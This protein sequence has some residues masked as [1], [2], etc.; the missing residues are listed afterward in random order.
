MSFSLQLTAFEE[1]KRRDQR[2]YLNEKNK[3]SP[4]SAIAMPTKQRKTECSIVLQLTEK[5]EVGSPDRIRTY[6]L[7]VN[8]MW[9]VEGGILRPC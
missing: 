4:V 3:T 7:S 9:I 5:V 6:G 8:P 2:K 1:N